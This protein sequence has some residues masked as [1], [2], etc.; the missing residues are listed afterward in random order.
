MK[1]SLGPTRLYLAGLVLLGLAALVF[2]QAAFDLQP[3]VSPSQPSQIVL[4]YTLQTIVFLVLTIFA[5]VLARSLFKLLME[6]RADKPGARF[7]TR[8]VMSMIILT[9]IPAVALFAFAFGLVNRSLDKWFSVPVDTIFR[10]TSEIQTEWAAEHEIAARGAL[11]EIGAELPDDLDRAAE[12]LRLKAIAFLDGSGELVQS[13]D[14]AAAY[15]HEFR[16]QLLPQNP[17]GRSDTEPL[18]ITQP[19]GSLL[20]LVRVEGSDNIGFVVAAFHPPEHFQELTQTIA[21][22]RSNYNTLIEN[23]LFFRD[24]YVLILVLMTI[25]V[26]FAAVWTGLFMSKRITV[27]LEAL[28]GATREI[29]AGNLDH[30]VEVQAN[31]ELGLLVGLFN[32]MAGQLKVTTEELDV[33]RRYTETILESIPTGV[34]SIDDEYRVTKINR[35]ARTMFSIEDPGT[36]NDI[37]SNDDLDQIGELLRICQQEGTTTREMTLQTDRKPPDIGTRGEGVHSAVIASGLTAGGFVLVVEDLTEVAKAQKATAWREV[38]QRLA[39][40]IKNPLTPIQLSAERIARNLARTPEIDT[41]TASVINEC[42]DSIVGEVGSL[43]ELVNE[44]GRV[45][46]LPTSTRKPTPV[47]SLIDR[48]LALYEDRFDGTRVLTDIPDDLPELLMDGQQ[49]KR[50]LINL[51][52]NAL[53][54]MTG[55]TDKELRIGCELVRDNTMARVSIADSGPGI[56][57]EDRERLFAPYFS[58]RK[59]GTGLGLAIASRIVADHGG[60]IGAESNGHGARFIVE[61]PIWQES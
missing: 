47:K 15:I 23:R 11:L 56:A 50:V 43:K 39:H 21:E 1:L 17:Q 12:N 2:V 6:R 45:A 5:F 59:E 41:H 8:L 10:T 49:I 3:F 61:L 46:R 22:Q 26:L 35:A 25:L 55:M 52:D 34:I 60:Y 53:D 30:R 48:T 18:L 40:E 4:L 36:L 28:A 20:G 9:L 31:D 33:R 38:A 19:D 13:S 16:D 24:T 54:A 7:K 57:P 29:A 51:I 42:V 32:D 37:L 14:G 44:F 27:P 58:T